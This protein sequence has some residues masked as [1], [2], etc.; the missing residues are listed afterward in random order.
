MQEAD[1]ELVREQEHLTQQVMAEVAAEEALVAALASGQTLSPEQ[2]AAAQ[3][4]M[5]E[6]EELPPLPD[7]DDSD[8]EE[9][10]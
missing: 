1:A 2:M 8:M 6:Q 3:R 10:K 9:R 4:L 7:S 5:A